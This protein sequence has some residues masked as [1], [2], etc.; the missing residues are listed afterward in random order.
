MA[1]AQS[2]IGTQAS[3]LA[4]DLTLRSSPAVTQIPKFVY[5]TAW[6][7][8]RTA[9]LVYKAIKNGFRGID[10]AAQPKHYD[11]AS[12]GRGVARAVTDGLARRQD[13]FVG[14]FPAPSLGDKSS[15]IQTKF[16]PPNGQSEIKPYSTDSPIQEQVRQS[17]Q[18][19]LEN[20]KVDDQTPYLDSVV[21]HSP[22]QD[23]G[24]T[25]TVWKTLEEYT[26]DTIRNLGIS[27]TD[28]DTLKMLHEQAQVKPAVV[29]NRFY[30]GT[31]YE[32]E[33]REFCN[34][35]GIIFQSFWTLS[36]NPKLAK[37]PPVL[38]VA[39][40][41]GVDREVAYYALVL[42]LEGLIILNGTTN[43]S[44]MGGDLAGIDKVGTW[45][46]SDG[47]DDWATALESF[48]VLIGQD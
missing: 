16:T 36:A 14:V 21:I 37:S 20:F 8:D 18:S 31:A 34:S 3:A 13:L 4:R 45:A 27:N 28:L 29:Q 41:A 11:E 25:L 39:Q 10:T 46:E 32:V 5:G 2:S 17:L 47:A 15:K 35:H 12:V 42:G 30:N 33:L 40:L 38:D 7:K 6:K 23:F 26:P 43:E 1:V 24:D 48:K 19:S 9:D 44:H 22:Y